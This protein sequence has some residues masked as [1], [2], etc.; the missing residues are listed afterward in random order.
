MPGGGGCARLIIGS[1]TSASRGGPAPGR[2]RGVGGADGACGSYLSLLCKDS[3]GPI[4]DVVDIVDIHVVTPVTAE[5]C[6]WGTDG[7]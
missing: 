3:N 7:T 4:D 2:H 5:S 6:S 1:R